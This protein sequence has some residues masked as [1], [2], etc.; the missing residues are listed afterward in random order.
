MF[1]LGWLHLYPANAEVRENSV[2][3]VVVSHFGF[4]SV[5]VSRIIYV[6][7]EPQNLYGFAYGTLLEH[8]EMGEERFTISWN[9]A[10][11]SVWF[12]VLA[13][14]KPGHILAKI[15]HPFSRRLQ[16]RFARDSMAAMMKAVAR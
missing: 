11:D 8:A 12:D 3:A 6:E 16:R 9:A 13:F 7:E 2:V 14:S 5:N 1:N 15:G 10:E 4:W